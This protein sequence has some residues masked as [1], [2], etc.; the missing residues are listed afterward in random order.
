[1]EELIKRI[2]EISS[3]QDEIMNYL[4]SFDDV[5]SDIVMKYYQ[6]QL[7]NEEA[8]AIHR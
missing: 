4:K 3:K 1:M 7:M 2:E 6:N 5:L 8:A